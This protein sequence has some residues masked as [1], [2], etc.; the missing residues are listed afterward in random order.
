MALQRRA[1]ARILEYDGE[2]LFE[3]I[4]RRP[5]ERFMGAPGVADDAR[6]IA[7]T[8]SFWILFYRD[9]HMCVSQK[10]VED[11]PYVPR[12]GLR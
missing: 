5:S 8:N 3:R 2:R 11:I 7:G 12:H 10:P 1:A 4:L 6:Q 9:L